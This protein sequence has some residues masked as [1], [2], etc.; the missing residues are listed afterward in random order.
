MRHRSVKVESLIWGLSAEQKFVVVRPLQQHLLEEP[1]EKAGFA[2]PAW[3][4]PHP[5]AERPG[6]R[7]AD[8]KFS[9]HK[10]GTEAVE[11]HLVGWSR[12]LGPAEAVR[13]STLYLHR[14][15]V[16]VRENI[17]HS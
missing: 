2:V 6:G 4:L 12:K 14:V 8:L 15:Q 3:V 10:A 9:A 1:W 7:L 13:E 5:P 11:V 16:V 17:V